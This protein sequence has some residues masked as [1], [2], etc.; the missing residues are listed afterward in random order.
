MAKTKESFAKNGR[1]PNQKMKPYII[2]Q[3][4]LKNTN[5]EHVCDAGDIAAYLA[6]C[7]IYAERHSIYKDID[8][9]NKAMWMLENNADIEE[10]EEAI[11]SDVDNEEKCIVYKHKHGFYVKNRPFDFTDLQLLSE[12]IN[13]AKF[14]S[15]KE[16]KNLKRKLGAFANK[17]DAKTLRNEVYL[18]GRKATTNDY[19]KYFIPTISEAIKNNHKIRFHYT[20][21]TIQNRNQQVDRRNGEFYTRSP[22]QMIISD[23]N[24]YLLAFDS[25]KEKIITYR[26]D[27]MKDVIELDEAREGREEFEKIDIESYN[28]RVF[29]MFG[30]EKK[31]VKMRFTNRMLDTVVEKLGTSSRV[32]YTVDDNWH[33]VV[34]ADVEISDQFFGWVCGLR[35]QATILEPPEVVDGMKR[36]LSDIT[37]R[38]E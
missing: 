21:Y 22:F 8:A 36:F 26:I 7:G 12:C 3:F 24:Y 17:Y 32:W 27:R 6:D 35:K 13:S 2:L 1:Q 37:S 25:D 33:F 19:V 30:G 16:S 34:E 5:E 38:Y 10:A 11:E 14:I 18:V 9:I 29:S 28:Q 31:R 15:K 23:G 20:K 4:L